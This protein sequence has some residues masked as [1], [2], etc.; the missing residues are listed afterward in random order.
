MD[1]VGPGTND[2]VA[3]DS[4]YRR[5]GETLGV[6]V[7]DMASVEEVEE[8]RQLR[9]EKEDALMALQVAQAAADSYPNTTKAPEA[10]SP[11]E[12]LT[13]A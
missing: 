7:E 10:G 6:S 12:A 4:G 9:Q 8:K 2:N 1:A 11:A 5:L 3:F 13:G